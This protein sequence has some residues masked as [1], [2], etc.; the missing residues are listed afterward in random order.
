M[1]SPGR[2]LALLRHWVAIALY[3]FYSGTAAVAP[4]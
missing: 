4:L 2:H 1:V 3:Y